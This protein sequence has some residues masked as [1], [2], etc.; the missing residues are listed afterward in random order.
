MKAPNGQ[1]EEPRAAATARKLMGLKR[2]AP[3]GRLFSAIATL[4]ET[5]G[6]PDTAMDI[7]PGRT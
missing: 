5:G 6:S 1:P 3:Q 4:S 7:E 2:L